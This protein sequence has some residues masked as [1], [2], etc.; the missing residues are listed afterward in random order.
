MANVPQTNIQGIQG[1]EGLL[2]QLF[3]YLN[4]Q[5]G[6][7]MAPSVSPSSMPTMQGLHRMLGSLNKAPMQVMPG[8]GVDPSVGSNAFMSS[9]QL[10]SNPAR[11]AIRQQ[12]IGATGDIMGQNLELGQANLF[13][14]MSMQQMIDQLLGGAAGQLGQ[15]GTYPPTIRGLAKSTAASG[16]GGGGGMFGFGGF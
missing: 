13:N 11:A 9:N 2:G 15:I 10:A 16:T 12:Q 5:S 3:A 7:T 4:G 14:N 8:G 6:S 1:A